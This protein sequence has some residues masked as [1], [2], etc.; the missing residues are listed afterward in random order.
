MG[1][2]VVVFFLGSFVIFFFKLWGV[3]LNKK[4]L[5]DLENEIFI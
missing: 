3:F 4:E 1:L 5:K 2:V